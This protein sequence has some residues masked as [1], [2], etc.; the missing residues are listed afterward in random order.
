VH[1]R[2]DGS[3]HDPVLVESSGDGDIDQA[4]LSCASGSRFGA[5]AVSGNPAETVWVLGYYWHVGWSGFAP[6][7][8]DGKAAASCEDRPFDQPSDKNGAAKDTVLSYFIGTDGVVKN[9]AVTASSGV[10]DLDRQAMDCVS[11][12][13]FFPVYRNG[14][15]VEV[16]RTYTVKWQAK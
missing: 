9:V 8:P 13:R 5:I 11:A 10:P 16:D 6:A 12:W 14:D 7:S 1:V 3:L 2:P 15:A 4:V